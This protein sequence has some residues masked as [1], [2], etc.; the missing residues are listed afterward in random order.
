M[1][2]TAALLLFLRKTVGRLLIATGSAGVAMEAVIVIVH[3]NTS[4][5]NA[6]GVDD[7][8]KWPSCART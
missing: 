8:G 2:V 6:R 3:S 7:Q 5:S 1:L 4:L